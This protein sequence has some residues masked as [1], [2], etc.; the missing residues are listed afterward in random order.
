MVLPATALTAAAVTAESAH[1]DA[2]TPIGETNPPPARRNGPMPTGTLVLARH[3]ESEFNAAQ[4]FTGLL[5]V[6]SHRVVRSRLARP[7]AWEVVSDGPAL[8]CLC[9]GCGP[10]N[11]PPVCG[12]RVAWG[13]GHIDSRR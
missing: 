10:T 9:A 1:P 4:I 13:Q 11:P 7:A 8:C 3:V 6:D 2:H 5:D 12:V